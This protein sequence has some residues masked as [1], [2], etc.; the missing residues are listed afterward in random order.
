MLA[1]EKMYFFILIFLS[2]CYVDKEYNSRGI[3]F[4]YN[5]N[6]LKHIHCLCVRF[7]RHRIKSELYYIYYFYRVKSLL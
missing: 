5:Y 4:F 2:A 6:L 7:L 1:M 3:V